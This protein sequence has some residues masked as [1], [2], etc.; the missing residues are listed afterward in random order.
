VSAGGEV[1][2]AE[3]WLVAGGR[4]RGLD[5]HWE[6]LARGLAGAGLRTRL[7]RTAVEAALPVTGRWFP[8]L[9]VLADGEARLAVRPAPARR[10][11]VVAWIR[12]GPDPRRAPRRKGPDLARLG[13][14]RAEAAERGAGE[15][16]LRDGEGRLLEGAYTSLLWWEGDVLWAVPDDAPILDGV[17]RRLLLGLAARDGVEIRFRRPAPAELDGREVWLT[18][19]LHGIRAVTPAAAGTLR[20]GAP[21]RAAAWQA[22]L[23]ALAAP[24]GRAG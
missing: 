11:D 4:A 22:R 7:S 5:L 23:E 3:S 18:S 13:A 6:R 15:A 14:L 12:E 1:A 10:P 2:A 24:V 8:R 16:L 21:L 9:D 17:T 20:A 19:A